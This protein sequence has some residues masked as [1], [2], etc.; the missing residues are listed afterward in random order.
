MPQKF[1]NKLQLSQC[2]ILIKY[3]FLSK[4]NEIYYSN[5]MK[6]LFI[7]LAKITLPAT[8][9]LYG[10]YLAVKSFLSKDFNQRL[11]ELKAKDKEIISPIRLQAYERLTILMERLTPSNLLPRLNNNDLNVAIFQQ[12][13]L[14]EIKQEVSHNY[15]QQVYVSDEAWKAVK[16]AVDKLTSIVNE[17]AATL[18]PEAP[19]VELAKKI[20]DFVLEN[21]EDF[22]TKALSVLK[23]EVRTYF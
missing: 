11:L 21:D 20:F 2:F 9:V 4:C 5:F 16:E 13:L 7:D 15:S 1:N 18:N 23:N 6:E 3:N 10:M 8:L 14:N 19:S 22:T 12:L 17:S